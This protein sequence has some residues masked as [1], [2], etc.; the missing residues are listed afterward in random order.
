LF[1]LV[2]LFNQVFLPLPGRVTATDVTARQRVEKIFIITYY[3]M[4]VLFIL[5]L[6]IF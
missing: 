6:F 1:Q 3:V 4:S 2:P 5:Y